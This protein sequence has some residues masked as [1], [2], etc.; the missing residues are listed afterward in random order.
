[1][2]LMRFFCS[3]WFCS[4]VLMNCSDSGGTP[5]AIDSSADPAGIPDN[6]DCEAAKNYIESRGFGITVTCDGQKMSLSSTTSLPTHEMMHGIVNWI[7]RVPVAYPLRWEINLEPT[8]HDNY[9]NTTGIGPNAVAINGVPIFHYSTAPDTSIDPTKNHSDTVTNGELD[10]CGGHSGQGD[11]YHYHS[12]PICLVDKENLDKP[13][14]YSLDG[15]PIYFGSAPA[16]DTLNVLGLSGYEAPSGLDLCNG[17]RRGDGSWVFYSTEDPPYMVGCHHTDGI[18]N[19]E[20]QIPVFRNQREEDL[21]GNI[22]GEVNEGISI[23]PATLVEGG[24]YTQKFTQNGAEKSIQYTVETTGTTQTI[25]MKFSKG[26][27]SVGTK[28]YERMIR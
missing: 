1:M 25:E 5:T 20:Y 4:M 12:A 27:Q 26:D 8:W 15:A 10:E 28:T 14:A 13:I 7:D 6:L 2:K 24:V 19:R 3:L 16:S 21:L 18:D 23:L 9:T 17:A 22:Q 11:D